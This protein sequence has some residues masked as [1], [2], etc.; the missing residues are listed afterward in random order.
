MIT[1]VAT[2]FDRISAL[3]YIHAF[4]PQNGQSQLDLMPQKDCEMFLNWAAKSN[5]HS[6][7]PPNS[8]IFNFVNDSDRQWVESK[9][10]SHLLAPF[11]EKISLPCKDK[12]IYNLTYVF[13]ENWHNFILSFIQK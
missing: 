9:P 5:C 4:V 2:L 3:R 1:G 7:P 8:Q 10:T 13:A 6:F 11:V 12:K